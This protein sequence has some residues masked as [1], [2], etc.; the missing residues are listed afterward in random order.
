[1]TELLLAGARAP[2]TRAAEVCS[3]T[4]LETTREEQ[5]PAARPMDRKTLF[6]VI[7]FGVALVLLVVLN[8]G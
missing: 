5:T 8:M 1:V 7:A 6:I 4:E 3:M 2:V